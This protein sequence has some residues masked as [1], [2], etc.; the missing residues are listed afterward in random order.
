MYLFAV[1]NSIQR[2]DFEQYLLHIS[3]KFLKIMKAAEV[4]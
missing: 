2:G 1:F 4:T 3:H